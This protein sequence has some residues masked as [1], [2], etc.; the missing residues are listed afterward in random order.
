MLNENANIIN[1]CLDLISA[2]KLD[3]PREENGGPLM[4]PLTILSNHLFIKKRIK[5]H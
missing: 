4:Y 5:G 2:Q 3:A 1:C